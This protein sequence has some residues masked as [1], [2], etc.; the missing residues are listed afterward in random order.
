LKTAHKTM[1]QGNSPDKQCPVINKT[2][3]GQGPGWAPVFSSRLL[4]H[5]PLLCLNPAWPPCR[6]NMIRPL[7]IARFP[8]VGAMSQPIER[9]SGFQQQILIL[10]SA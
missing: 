4:I 1:S 5:A 6:C 7:S 8:S 3:Q 10:L 9:I 2:Y